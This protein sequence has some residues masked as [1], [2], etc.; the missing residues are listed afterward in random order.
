MG[1]PYIERG[2][3]KIS[4]ISPFTVDDKLVTEMYIEEYRSEEV[5]YFKVQLNFHEWMGFSYQGTLNMLNQEFAGNLHQI[6][7]HY[8][9]AQ[10]CNSNIAIM[11]ECLHYIRRYNS[12][13]LNHLI[14]KMEKGE[15]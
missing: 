8:S 3:H 13:Y 10:N 12:D 4:L 14:E 2:N 6:Y 11:R 7:E 5:V 9:W 15:K 1:Y